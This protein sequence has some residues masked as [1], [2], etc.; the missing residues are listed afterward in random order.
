MFDSPIRGVD[1][2]QSWTPTW[3]S[4]APV[5]AID[6]RGVPDP[7]PDPVFP[8]PVLKRI[9]TLTWIMFAFSLP[10]HAGGCA[11]YFAGLEWSQTRAIAINAAPA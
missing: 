10:T 5:R 4:P 7:V 6:F 9:L 1:Q 3:R 2:M 11:R 8:H